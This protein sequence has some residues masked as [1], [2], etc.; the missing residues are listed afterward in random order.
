M[1]LALLAL[2]AVA[3]GCS[4][5]PES[6]PPPIQ[7]TAT[8]SSGAPRF[9]SFLEMNQPGVE[10]YFIADI[11]A[12][13][14][15]AWRWTGPRPAM[16]FILEKTEELKFVMDFAIPGVTFEQTGPVTVSVHV[17]GRLLGRERYTV[18]GEEHLES[19][20]DPSWLTAGEDTIVELE[21]DPPWL[22]PDNQT[23]LGFILSRAGFVE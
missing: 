11:R 9:R 13:E 22:A 12:L 19:P 14:G 1:R 17:N 18:Y 6:Y 23:K 3:L 16:R 5:Y 4:N 15:N 10:G 8:T 2:F 21:I 20:V 7:R